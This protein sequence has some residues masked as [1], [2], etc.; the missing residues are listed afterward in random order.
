[1]STLEI[2]IVCRT[3][4]WTPQIV[5]L[6]LLL[7]GSEI[8]GSQ[9]GNPTSFPSIGIIKI[10]T[11]E[12]F[13]ERSDGITAPYAAANTLHVRTRETVIRR[14]LLFTTGDPVNSEL[15]EQTERN[16]RALPFLRDARVETKPI[17]EDGDGRPE[18]VDV[19]VLTWDTW[20]L[21]PQLDFAT[22]ND[23]ATWTIGISEK[24]LLGL[25]KAASISRRRTLDRFLTRFD[26]RDHQLAGSRLTLTTSVSKLSDGNEGFFSLARPFFSIQDRWAMT[27]Q[28]G[29]FARNDPL[30][31]D[32]N[33]IGHLRHVARWSDLEL[34]RAIHRRPRRAIRLHAAYRVRQETIGTGARDFGILETGLSAVSHRFV[35]LT[36]VN[37][38]ERPEDINLGT[39]TSARLGFSTPQLGG[40]DG[41]IVF[42]A[43][44][45]QR[46][47]DFGPGHFLLSRVQATTRR[48]QSTLENTLIEAKLQYLRQH[49]LRHSFLAKLDFRHG[50]NL[51]PEVQ[52]RLGAESGLRGYPI[53]QFVGTRSLLLSSEERWFFADDLGQLLSLGVAAFLDSGFAWPEGRPIDFG[54]LR[55]SAGV[56]LLMG[57]SRLSNRPGIRLD[58]GYALNPVT[59]RGRWVLIFGSDV[60]F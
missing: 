39:Q 11:N 38:F 13:D 6:L 37:S 58:L 45:Y 35:R 16:L 40:E 29:G 56:S 17:D 18:R 26:Y 54:D 30:I 9:D 2:L 20:S 49:V 41:T 50:H 5:G 42:I 3:A 46:G 55:T 34:A 53:R 48:R 7:S 22:V 27:I 47:L 10:I 23:H 32:G 24:N 52:L 8:K 15:L 36:H 60:Q 59:N 1:M 51:D 44:S 19:R 14:E 57:T 31:E 33:Q 43:A 4:R 28:A 25:G 12:V 21:S